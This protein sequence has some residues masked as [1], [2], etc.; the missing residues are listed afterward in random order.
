MDPVMAVGDAEDIHIQG[1]LLLRT[2]GDLALGREYVFEK[3]LSTLDLH[4]V[5]T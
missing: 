2:P 1:V 5:R 3:L 4:R